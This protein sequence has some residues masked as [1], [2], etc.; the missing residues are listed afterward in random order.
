MTLEGIHTV[1]VTTLASVFRE[2]AWCAAFT[3]DHS[4]P[5]D[6]PR[7]NTCP[8]LRAYIL[9]TVNKLCLIRPR[10]PVSGS[11][12]TCL[13]RHEPPRHFS[14]FLF[15]VNTFPNRTSTHKADASTECF[16]FCLLLKEPFLR[17]VACV[18]RGPLS[19]KG[20][21]PGGWPIA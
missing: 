5:D 8:H 9:L 12:A 1:P 7:R 17:P 11:P 21:A 16:G 14:L 15:S 3:E 2:E 20:E 6:N 13:R 4:F 19:E 10:F 18:S